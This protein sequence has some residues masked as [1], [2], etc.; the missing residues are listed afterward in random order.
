MPEFYIVAKVDRVVT[1]TVKL[2]IEAA[3]EG[4]AMEKATAALGEYPAEV[5][6]QDVHRIQTVKSHQW[7]P[8]SIEFIKVTGGKEFA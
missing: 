8:K 2:T 5:T 1:S 7:I 4:E 3:H 6:D